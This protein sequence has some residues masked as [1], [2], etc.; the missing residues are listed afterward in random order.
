MFSLFDLLL[1]IKVPNI[2]FVYESR[3]IQEQ[4]L[5]KRTVK[6]KDLKNKIMTLKRRI[7]LSCIVSV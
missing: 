6:D 1:M 7:V 5:G 4:T 3:W 2:D